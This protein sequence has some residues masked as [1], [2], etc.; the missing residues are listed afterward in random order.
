MSPIV[1][2]IFPLT[3]T[4]QLYSPFLSLAFT[5]FYPLSIVVHL[6]GYGGIFDGILLELFHLES[7]S[8]A[9]KVDIIYGL[10]YLLLSLGA[11]YSRWLFYLLFVVAL[12]FM[13][14]MFLG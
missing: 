1:H 10:G 8:M 3:S 14:W 9:I 11:I 5:L 7:E 13:G 4:L 12:G 6:I 2:M